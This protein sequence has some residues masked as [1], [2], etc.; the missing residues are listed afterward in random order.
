MKSKL[1]LPKRPLA[2][3]FVGIAMV[4]SGAGAAM[5]TNTGWK[6]H[7]QASPNGYASFSGSYLWYSKNDNHG[8]FRVKGTLS[9]KKKNSRPNM[10]LVRVEGYSART[11]TA[12]KDKN[13]TIPDLVYYDYASLVTHNGYVQTCEDSLIGNNC[14]SWKKY[15]NPYY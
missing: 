12:P 2:A 5:A 3:A 6:T 13:L 14:S 7:T 8:G 11:H 1:R 4:L 9:D 10:F 15:T